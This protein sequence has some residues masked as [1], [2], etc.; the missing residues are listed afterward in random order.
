MSEPTADRIEDAISPPVVPSAWTIERAVSVWQQMLADL[1]TDEDLILD[2][3][4]IAAALLKADAKDPRAGLAALIDASV[5]AQRRAEEARTLAAEQTERARRYER[6]DQ[7]FRDLINGIMAATELR[8]AAGRWARAAIVRAPP[9]VLVT[10]EQLIPSEY[11][12]IERSVRKLDLL[13][14]LKVGVVVDGAVLSNGGETL[15]IAR[16]K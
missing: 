3:N 7:R 5:W 6:H 4:V 11:I 15:R 8:K 2:E 9:S 16:L 13:A 12:K 14:D 10:D 1:T